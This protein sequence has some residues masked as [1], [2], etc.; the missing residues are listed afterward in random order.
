[1]LQAYAKKILKHNHS[2]YSKVK[3]IKL[4]SDLKIKVNSS[5]LVYRIN[6]LRSGCERPQLKTVSVLILG[7]RIIKRCLLYQFPGSVELTAP[8]YTIFCDVDDVQ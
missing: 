3:H 1:M 2:T 6:V 4:I 8:C 7:F 5:P